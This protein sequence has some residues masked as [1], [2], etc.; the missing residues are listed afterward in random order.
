MNLPRLCEENARLIGLLEARGIPG[1]ATE[2]PATPRPADLLTTRQK[3]ALFRR[4]FLGRSDVY[5]VRW[6]NRAGKSGYAPACWNE[7]R[8]G[9][10]ESPASNAQTAATARRCHW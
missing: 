6:E 10:C 4:L 7:W 3:V 1:R 8:P 5:P 2:P 9:V